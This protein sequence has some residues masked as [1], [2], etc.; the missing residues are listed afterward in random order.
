LFLA[1]TSFAYMTRFLPALS[2]ILLSWGLG[3]P[4]VARAQ[5]PAMSLMG[6]VQTDAHEPLPG[7]AITVVHL[8]SGVRHAAASDATGHFVI[9]SLLVGDPYLIHVGEGGYR[10]Q[11]VE[12]IFFRKRQNGQ[13][14]R[15]AKQASRY[16]CP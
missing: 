11:T 7:A 2:L 5:T 9:G 10:P 3:R 6:S 12:N 1:L 14:H 8:P 4:Q 13:C 15:H 16:P